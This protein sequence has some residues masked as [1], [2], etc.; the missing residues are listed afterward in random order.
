MEQI[1][2]IPVLA[3]YIENMDRR[4]ALA[5][6]VGSDPDYIW[7]IA[8]GRRKASFKL[9]QRIHDET[10]GEVSKHILRPDIF[11]EAPKRRQARAA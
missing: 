10:S 5:A 6:A 4:K 8:T 9:A 1:E 3:D 11:G 2:P 7:Q